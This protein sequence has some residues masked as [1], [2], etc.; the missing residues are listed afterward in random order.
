MA[1]NRVC[2]EPTLAIGQ[3]VDGRQPGVCRAASVDVFFRLSV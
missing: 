1:V 2:V 3:L